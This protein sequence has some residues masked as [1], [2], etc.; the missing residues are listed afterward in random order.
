MFPLLL[1]WLLSY[2]NTGV[3]V[4]VC[5]CVCVF[6]PI[7]GLEAATIPV[8]MAKIIPNLRLVYK[9]KFPWCDP[10]SGF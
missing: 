10:P 2:K 8:P 1:P 4:C 5:V 9:P 6:R 7:E 3:C